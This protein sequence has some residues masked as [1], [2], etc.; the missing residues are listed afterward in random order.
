M[1]YQHLRRLL[2]QRALTAAL[3]RWNYNGCTTGRLSLAARDA[4]LQPAYEAASRRQGPGLDLR[5]LP[6]AADTRVVT[7]SSAA[8]VEEYRESCRSIGAS[9]QQRV[10]LVRTR[11]L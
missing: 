3:A 8:V 6:H 7:L 2:D 9:R 10:D 11:P 5:D 1:F 4:V